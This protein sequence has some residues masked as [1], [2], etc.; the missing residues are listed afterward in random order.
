MKYSVYAHVFPN[1]KAY[2]GITKQSVEKRWKN[3]K[4]YGKSQPIMRKAIKKYGWENIK[5]ITLFEDLSVDEACEIEKHFINDLR[6]FDNS[7]GYNSCHGGEK[8][9]PNESTKKMISESIKNK[10]VDADFREKAMDGMS[11]KKRSLEARKHISEAQKKRFEREEERIK[12]GNS[13][14]G[15]HRSE[16][17]K[18]KTSI[19]L[20]QFYSIEE[21]AE[22]CRQAM[23]VRNQMHCKKVRCIETNVEYSSVREASACFGL[24]HQNLSACLSGKRKT[25]G[26]YHWEYA[27]L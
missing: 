14:R 26:G 15:C 17:A 6:L 3:G 5:H 12:V 23:R 4:G 27:D 18:R 2:V 24:S 10:W 16:E 20:K 11:G 1:G 19:S 22:K 9:E 8:N 7:F 21:N 13:S 25:Y